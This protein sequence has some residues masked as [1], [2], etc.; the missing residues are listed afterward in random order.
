MGDQVARPALP[1]LREMLIHRNRTGDAEDL[2]DPETPQRPRKKP[3]TRLLVTFRRFSS[4]PF[5][6]PSPLEA[7][8]REQSLRNSSR[9]HL[10]FKFLFDRAPATEN[11]SYPTLRLLLFCRFFKHRLVFEVT[12]TLGLDF[13]RDTENC[14]SFLT[15][16]HVQ[17]CGA[18]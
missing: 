12:S 10:N 18:F 2:Q 14:A 17:L 7:R 5:R 6:F 4:F 9:V 13:R 16:E 11:A 8:S 1:A 3:F 15:E